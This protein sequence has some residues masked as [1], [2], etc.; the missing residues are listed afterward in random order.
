M[1]IKNANPP[2]FLERV[3]RESPRSGV[4]FRSSECFDRLHYTLV[5]PRADDISRLNDHKRMMSYKELR[6]LG[7]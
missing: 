5:F 2:M 7:N 3:V 1:I 6:S 4:V